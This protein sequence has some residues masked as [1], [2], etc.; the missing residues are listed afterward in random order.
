MNIKTRTDR[1]AGNEYVGFDWTE[2]CVANGDPERGWTCP[3]PRDGGTTLYVSDRV[4]RRMRAQV[5]NPANGWNDLANV[6]WAES[7]PV[8]PRAIK[9]NFT[10]DD[11]AASAARGYRLTVPIGM[12]NDYNGY[13]ATYREFQRGDHYRKAL[14]GW[15]PHSADYLATR[16]VTLGRQLRDPGGASRATSSRS[17]SS[18]GSC[19]STSS[20][21]TS[22]AAALG[23]VGSAAI[24]AF[25]TLLPDDG[26]PAGP[27][28]Q[29]GR[30]RALR[31]GAVRVGRRLELHRQPGRAGRAARRRRAGRRSPT[32]RARCR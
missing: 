13:I 24:A 12:A 23:T 18:T 20:S 2:R 32:A 7:E 16:L 28:N 6:A 30:R 26:G 17:G 3:D 29:P 14:T 19:A 8:D 25:E 10:H 1:V 9:G 31:R 15:G 22:K 4:Y 21:R 11:D 27:V 5:L